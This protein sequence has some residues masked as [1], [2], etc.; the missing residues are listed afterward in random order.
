MHN[1]FSLESTRCRAAQEIWSRLSLNDRLRPVRRLRHLIADSMKQLAHAVEQDVARP[2]DEVLA[3][4]IMPAADACRFLERQAS[5]LLRPRVIPGSQRPIWLFGSRDTVYRRPHGVVGVIGTWNY[6]V[7]LNAVPI[8]QGL[9]AGN[10]VLWKPSELTPKLAV[11]LHE[12]FLKAGFPP[13]LFIR[14]P[15]TREAGPEIAEAALDHVVFT[16]SAGVG[17]KLARRLGERLISSTLELSGCD[18][19][20]VAADADVDM[21]AQAAWYGVTLNR[22]QTCIAVRR[23]FVDK[24]VYPRFLERLRL[25]AAN[26]SQPLPLMQEPQAIQAARLVAESIAT[27]GKLLVPVDQLPANNRGSDYPAT[28]IVDARPEMAVCREAIFAPVAAVIPFDDLRQVIQQ[29][30]LCPY[31]LGAS[32]FTR[33]ARTAMLLAESL[34]TGLVTVND[35][36]AQTAHPATPF[37]GRHDSG[38]GVTQGAE[39][40]LAMTVPQVVSRRRGSFRPHFFPAP[41]A[42]QATA[43]LLEGL[44]NWRHGGRFRQRWSGF[45]KMVRAAI[46]FPLKGSR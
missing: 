7:L 14:L 3:T 11:A 6:P 44:L 27:G 33:D 35:V 16:G 31:A 38:W 41:A 28:F 4:D 8:V 13:D 30:S 25:A 45:W 21:A 5:R 2:A 26:H 22:G 18:A 43:E 10:G 29:Q 9:A 37:G 34:S 23:I 24:A 20:I 1:P 46:R 15:A 17:R 32:I 12:L 36:I 19:M 42:K 40:L 39:G